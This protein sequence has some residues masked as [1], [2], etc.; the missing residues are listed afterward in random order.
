MIAVTISNAHQKG[1]PIDLIN[2]IKEAGFEHVFVEWYN[3]DWEIS[4]QQQLDYVRK[5][6]LNVIFRIWDIRKSTTSGWK[7]KQEKVLWN[8]IKMISSSAEK[9]ALI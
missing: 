6:G 9:M 2:S 5:L 1:T 3:K 8:D 7:V 4:Q